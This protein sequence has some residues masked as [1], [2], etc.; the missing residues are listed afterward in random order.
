MKADFAWVCAG[1]APPG[2]YSTTTAISDLPGMLG[3]AW[4]KWGVTVWPILCAGAGVAVA[5]AMAAQAAPRM[6]RI[7][8]VA[9]SFARYRCPPLVYKKVPRS[10]KDRVPRRNDQAAEPAARSVR[11]DASDRAD[12][13]RH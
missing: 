12:P 6:D 2:A 13:Q 8:M 4:A 7:F 10:D 9:F 11:E 3:I 5:M 1:D